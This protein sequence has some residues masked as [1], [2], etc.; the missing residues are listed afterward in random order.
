MNEWTRARLRIFSRTPNLY[1]MN[2]PRVSPT[3]RRSARKAAFLSLLKNFETD[4]YLFSNRTSGIQIRRPSKSSMLFCLS[5]QYDST[6]DVSVIRTNWKRT[7]SS[8]IAVRRS[9]STAANCDEGR[10]KRRKE[11]S[12]DDSDDRSSFDVSL[13]S[14]S[15][16]GGSDNGRISSK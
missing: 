3:C 15:A 7:C 4:Q 12:S 6:T 9:G 14:S 16:I 5:P 11:G 13:S 10:L 2:A 1:E 8:P